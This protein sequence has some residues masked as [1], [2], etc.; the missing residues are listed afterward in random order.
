MKTKTLLAFLIVLLGALGALTW[1]CDPQLRLN[2]AEPK[3]PIVEPPPPPP[4]PPP[5]PVV[6]TALG[7]VQQTFNLLD[8]ADRTTTD[9]ANHCAEIQWRIR[10]GSVTIVASTSAKPCGQVTRFGPL[11]P[12]TY[13]VDQKAIADDGASATSSYG[14]F[15]VGAF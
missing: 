4:P 6:V 13:Y 15:T 14:P 5:A 2:P 8:C 11:A 7:E 10:I 1:G 12:G 9:P 3:P